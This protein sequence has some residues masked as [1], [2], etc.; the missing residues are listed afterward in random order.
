M[1]NKIIILL[2]FISTLCVGCTIEDWDKI[3]KRTKNMKFEI[4]LSEER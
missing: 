4:P 1:N 3:D 2:L